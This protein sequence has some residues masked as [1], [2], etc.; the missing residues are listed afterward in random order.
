MYCQTLY[1]GKK[2]TATNDGN[3]FFGKETQNKAGGE[4]SDMEAVGIGAGRA[5][6]TFELS[7][8]RESQTTKRRL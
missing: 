7:H 6:L 5:I 4:V 8:K 1:S 2:L 3:Q